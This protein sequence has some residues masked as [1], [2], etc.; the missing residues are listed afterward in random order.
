MKTLK[1]SILFLVILFSLSALPS[2]TLAQ[3]EPVDLIFF[4]GQGCPHCANE[5]VFLDDIAQQYP[6]LKIQK[7]ETY[8]NQEN[9][10]L[11]ETL[12]AAYG[13]KMGGVPTT[14]IEN[15]VIVGFNDKIAKNIISIIEDCTE[16][17]CTNP[18]DKITSAK[19][20]ISQDL[21]LSAVITA[22]AVDA[23]NPCAFAV[24]V[25]LIGTIIVH[26]N[27]KKALLAGL[28]FTLS[29][30]ISYFLMGLGLYSAI[31]AA[32]I[33]K[34]FYIVVSILAIII[35]LFNLKDYFW[36]G[37]WFTME[38]PMK[39]RPK[40]KT[41]I[42]SVTS[43]P[44]AFII[45]FAVSLFLLPCTS[46]PYIVIL[47]LLASATE[48]TYAISLLLLYNFIFVLPMLIITGA[49]YFGLTTTEK[50]EKW[51]KKNLKRLHLVAGLIILALGIGMLIALGLGYM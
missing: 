45:G 50:A 44:G 4:Y 49:I 37:K 30:F 9:R 15:D 23:I 25:L 14:F 26:S 22:A 51:R 35:G 16:K 1:K 33:T 10:E 18:L 46:G 21:T 28:A 24:L 27:R 8:F 34:T 13:K 29:I 36:Y 38:V 40:L 47:G 43:I 39:W 41:L 11:F 12:S 6:S 7:Y 19:P 5:E 2:Q 42:R 3:E 31:Q 20:Q 32:A 17:A 48:K